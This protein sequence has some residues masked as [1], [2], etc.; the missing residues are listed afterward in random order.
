MSWQL[1]EKPNLA[2]LKKQAKQLLRAKQHR[3]LVDAQHTLAKEY[4][5]ASWAKLKLHVDSH[6]LTPAEKLKDAAASTLSEIEQRKLHSGVQNNDTNAVRLML[7]AGWPVDT[8]G[9]VGATALHSAVSH[10]N[11]IFVILV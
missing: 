4:G 2:H 8:L 10:G 3:N 6:G 11:M 1:P 5:F 9:D 7:Q